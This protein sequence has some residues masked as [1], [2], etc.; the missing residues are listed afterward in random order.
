MRSIPP[1]PMVAR[2]HATYDDGEWIALLFEDID[3][4][5][6]DLCARADTD[7]VGAAIDDLTNVCTPSPWPGAQ[8]LD[9][10]ARVQTSW[11]PQAD[12]VPRWLMGHRDDLEAFQRRLVPAVEG[13]T[14]C[15]RDVAA[16][17]I[18]ITADRVVFIDL[19]WVSLGAAWVDTM[20]LACAAVADGL[21]VRDADA[22]LARGRHARGIGAEVLTGYLANLAGAAYVKARRADPHNLPALQEFRRSRADALLTWLRSR[23]GW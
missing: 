18:L 4:R 8:R 21:P 10:A 22:V 6:P 11:W 9:A 16:D 23:T 15:Q 19:A 5:H 14:L 2:L 17:N 12:H 20:H 7:L 13:S 3:G 1:N